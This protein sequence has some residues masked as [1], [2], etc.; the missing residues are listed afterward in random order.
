MTKLKNNSPICFHFR[1]RDQKGQIL[2]SSGLTIVFNPTTH[3]FGIAKCNPKT[4][5][6]CRLGGRTVAYGRS[7]VNDENH[8]CVNIPFRCKK[9]KG[10]MTFENVKHEAFQ[11]ARDFGFTKYK[12]TEH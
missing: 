12:Q 11:I 6:F 7:I 8:H 2:G 9:H 3:L 1:S 10:E 5:N 4:D